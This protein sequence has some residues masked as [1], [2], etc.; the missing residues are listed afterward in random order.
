VATP[1]AA[2]TQ[3]AHQRSFTASSKSDTYPE[4]FLGIYSMTL[5]ILRSIFTLT[6]KAYPS[7]AIFALIIMLHYFHPNLKIFFPTH[8]VYI[9]FIYLSR[10]FCISFHAAEF[11]LI[12]R[13]PRI[14]SLPQPYQNTGDF[15]AYL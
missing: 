5:P 9:V 4:L 15:P 13:P 2:K 10:Y 1:K 8:R 7:P 12:M 14:S 3:L 6:R 11:S